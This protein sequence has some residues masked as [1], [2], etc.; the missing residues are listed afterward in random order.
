MEPDGTFPDGI[1]LS[2]RGLAAI[3]AASLSAFDDKP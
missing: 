2:L 1:G 3:F